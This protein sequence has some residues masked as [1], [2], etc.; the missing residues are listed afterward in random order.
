MA[1]MHAAY[2]AAYNGGTSCHTVARATDIC[3]PHDAILHSRL[4]GVGCEVHYRGATPWQAMHGAF[5][6]RFG[7]T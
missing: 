6:Y 7:A 5:Q 3:R 1:S 4:H 2:R